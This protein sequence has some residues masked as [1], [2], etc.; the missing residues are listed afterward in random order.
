MQRIRFLSTHFL[1][2][3]AEVWDKVKYNLMIEPRLRWV[4][5]HFVFNSH[6]LNC[7]WAL[8]KAQF[9]FFWKSNL[10]CDFDH[11]LAG[12]EVWKKLF[13]GRII[14]NPI[15]RS[16]EKMRFER[17][18]LFSVVNESSPNCRLVYWGALFFLIGDFILL[19][20]YYC[21][22]FSQKFVSLYPI[23]AFSAFREKSFWILF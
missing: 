5:V 16:S 22:S 11:I 7:I 12:A 14:F 10:N 2:M 8:F 9:T 20:G 15:L 4:E 6:D 18:I 3:I 17:V 1:V 21:D 23:R 19:A 13:S